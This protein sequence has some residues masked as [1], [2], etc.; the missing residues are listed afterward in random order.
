MI[1]LS[2]I[3]VWLTKWYFKPNQIILQYWNKTRASI[4]FTCLFSS[5]MSTSNF[6]RNWR[7]G[8]NN[9]GINLLTRE[10]EQKISSKAITHTSQYITHT[11]LQWI[12]THTVVI[13][14]FHQQIKLAFQ[15]RQTHTMLK[16]NLKLFCN[17][18]VQ[19]K[20]PIHLA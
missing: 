17:N 1:F 18:L 16:Q 13:L 12:I 6:C 14:A 15:Y 4:E 7:T 10:I 11:Q 20:F 19:N 8:E 9:Y 2:L 3:H 5:C